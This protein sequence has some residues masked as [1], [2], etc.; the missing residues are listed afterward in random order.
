MKMNPVIFKSLLVFLLTVP[1]LVTAQQMDIQG[2]VRQALTSKIRTDEDRNADSYRKPAETLAFFGLKNNMRVL[3]LMPAGGYYTKILGQ[4]LAD[5]GKLY[6]GLG[7]DAVAGKLSEWGLTRIE[8]LDDKFKMS[9]GEKRGFNIIDS[10]L[11][12]GV[13]GLDMVLT[14]RN[15]HDFSPESRKT[16]NTQVFN[17]LKSGGI[18]GVVDHTGRHM[19]PYNEETWRRLDP[20]MVIKEIQAVGFEFVDYSDLHYRPHD[21]LKTDTTVTSLNRDSD[22]FTFIFRKP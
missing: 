13:T 8:I 15:L 2:Q 11:D 4:V 12:F 17:A 5:N 1:V 20:V 6:E 18:Y 21:E 16:V 7:G 9:K 10:S 3:E 14:F 22:R 19:A